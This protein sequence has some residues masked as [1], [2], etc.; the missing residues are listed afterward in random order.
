MCFILHF[1]M[2]VAEVGRRGRC[3]DDR[4]VFHGDRECP[5]EFCQ[6]MER[7]NGRDMQRE[8][9]SVLLGTKNVVFCLPLIMIRIVFNYL[10]L[11][12]CSLFDYNFIVYLITCTKW[13]HTEL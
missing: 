2:L 7:Q 8:C 10:R 11:P 12:N 1:Y 3:F 9:Y 4:S 13:S 6:Q 5:G